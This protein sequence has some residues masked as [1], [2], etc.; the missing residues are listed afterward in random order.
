M[1]I[2]IH[3]EVVIYKNAIYTSHVGP[4]IVSVLFTF[5]FGSENRTPL[6]NIKL[7]KF[8]MTKEHNL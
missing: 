7:V 5:I 6:S 8:E 1:A 4:F 2:D 3:S